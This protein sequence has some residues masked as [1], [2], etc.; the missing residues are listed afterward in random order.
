M[1]SKLTF[2]V[3]LL[4]LFTSA[5]E[6]NAQRRRKKSSARKTAVRKK[7]QEPEKKETAQDLLR[8]YRFE[9]AIVLLQKEIELAKKKE[10]P[11]EALEAD[12][13]YAQMG[14]NM[15]LGTERVVFI[16]SLVVPK[17][18]V[19]SRFRL[20]DGSGK[21]VQLDKAV[22][23]LASIESG[24]AAYLNDFANRVLFAVPDSTGLLKLS[25]ADKM[26]DRW[27]APYRLVGMGEPDET[28]DYPFLMADGVTLYYAAKGRESLGG[29][30]IFVT[31]YNTST[32]EYV[33]AENMGMPFNSPANDYLMAI[34]ENTGVGWFVSDRNQ[35]ADK[36]CI[37]RFI[38]NSSREIYH[39]TTQNAA[40]IR[41]LARIS[42]LKESQA[43]KEAIA[44]AQ[45]RMADSRLFADSDASRT[46]ARYVINDRTVYTSLAEFKSA[47]AK[48]LAQEA[49][50]N[51]RQLDNNRTA[52]EMLRRLYVQK[53]DDRLASDIL[54][55][56]Q[57]N[58]QLRARI[59][60]GEKA[61]RRAEQEAR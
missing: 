28:Q 12:L 45:K 21:I 43:D 48:R 30:D 36:V 56:E 25:A 23:Q 61:M 41:R 5:P 42:S 31:R 3:A 39:I 16:D 55:L 4:M 26:G 50:D 27:T 60:A 10:R 35:P 37:Y 38:P 40:E 58:E 49:T 32:G 47:D 19:L 14:A 44:A 57:E 6:L 17:A 59:A 2:F 52:L 11:A 29:Y 20:S 53:H 13:R 8:D 24:E 46:A 1:A 51:R 33:K 22:R 34:D 18:E 7:K 15:L 54:K 9:D